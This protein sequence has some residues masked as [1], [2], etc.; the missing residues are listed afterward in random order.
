MTDLIVGRKGI[1]RIR[2]G[3]LGR[4]SCCQVLELQQDTSHHQGLLYV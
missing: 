4:A 3:P 1:I 2:M